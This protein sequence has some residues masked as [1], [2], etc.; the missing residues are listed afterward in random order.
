[1]RVTLGPHGAVFLD[2]DGTINVRLVDDYVTRPADLVL[3][4]GAAEAVAEIVRSGHKVVVVT[5]QRGISL[6][7]MT[8]TDLKA[9]HDHMEQLVSRAT[10]GTFTGI[11]YCPHDRGVCECR[12][13]KPGMLREASLRWPDIELSESVL[14]GDSA[15]DVAAATAAGMQAMRIG[16]DAPDLLTAVRK[17]LAWVGS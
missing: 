8:E 6:G 10:G 1:M 16:V 14:I 12:K 7:R 13:P 4:P 3:L 11:I 17:L 15:S 9:V 5:N 2:R